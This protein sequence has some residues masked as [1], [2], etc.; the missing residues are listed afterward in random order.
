M[1]LAGDIGGTKVNLAFFENSECGLT[2]T[3]FG[4]FPSRDHSSLEEIVRLF[5]AQHQLK[6]EFACFGIAGPVKEGKGQLTN[7]SWIVD[8]REL[9]HNLKLKQVW[10][11]NDLEANAHG[12]TGLA[13]EDFVDL[14]SCDAKA[15]GNIAV[16]SAGTGLGE[17]G[18]LW[19][20]NH[21]LAIPSEGGHSDFAPRTDL[22][23]ELLQ[24]LRGKFKQV[25]WENLLSGRGTVN[26]YE[27]L[28]DTGR[29]QEPAWLTAEFQTED[30]AKV[31]SRA[32]FSGK[33]DLCAQ[34][35][36]L[37]VQYYGA[38]AGNL[39]LKVLATGGVYIGGG[40]APKIIGKLRDGSFMKA[41]IGEGRMKDLLATFPVRVI[42]NDKTAL[43]GAARYAAMRGGQIL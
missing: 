6:V 42:L 22:D 39:A 23:I 36:D 29:G 37:F 17:G 21:H 24:Y 26:I 38:E 31:I 41:F 9:A 32:A 3:V 2:L 8:A 25:S 20:G 16:I 43:T 35:I 5:M 34:T 30:R 12:I 15:A 19:D 14:N 40:I 13:P 1:I 7:L 28:R 18:L 27:F 10:V 33:C 4:T 11:I